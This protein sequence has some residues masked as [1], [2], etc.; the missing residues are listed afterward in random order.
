MKYL[1][2]YLAVIFTIVNIAY[3]E[4][5]NPHNEEPAQIV[6]DVMQQYGI[7]QGDLK[8]IEEGFW[9]FV[10]ES[11]AV[12]A[13]ETSERATSKLEYGETDFYGT[14]IEGDGLRYIHIY[15]L[16]NLKPDKT[17]HYKFTAVKHDGTQEVTSGD[18]TVCTFQIPDAVRVPQDIGGNPP[19]VLDQENTYYLLTEDIDADSSAI[20]F[21]GAGSTLDLGGHTVVYNE[22][23]LRIPTDQWTPHRNG[24]SFGIKMRAAGANMRVFNGRIVQGEGNDTSSYVSLGFNPIYVSGAPNLEIAGLDINYT[25]VQ[26]TGI[27]CHWPGEGYS[28]HHNIVTDSGKYI[29]NRH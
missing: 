3:G 19:Y 14:T 26:I 25:G 20:I 15:Y 9:Q 6:K 16:R 28:I 4:L 18:M 24:S 5:K 29:I 27:Y 7:E 10:S 13:F 17:Y 1:L 11:S 23:P 12:V 21:T 22:I 8:I 2:Y